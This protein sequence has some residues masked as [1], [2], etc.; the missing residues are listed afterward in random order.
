M[1][2]II[3]RGEYHLKFFSP[4]H[5]RPIFVL[6]IIS[7]ILLLIPY[8]FKGI[9]KGKYT[10]FIGI[11][12]LAVKLGDSLYRIHFENDVWYN[13]MPFNLCNVSLIFAGIYFIT[14]KRLYFNF[15]YFWFSGAIIAVIIPGFSVYHSSLYIYSFIASH[16]FEIFAVFYAFIH[17]DERVTFNGLITSI[18]G[19]MGLIGLAFLWNGIYGTN[20]MFM[21]DYIIGA[22]SFIK[23]FWF[24][25]IALTGLFTLSMLLMFLPFVNNQKEDLEEVII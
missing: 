4:E 18:I 8:L 9:E 3:T 13:T 14:R 23:P 1:F 24:Y 6:I 7:I 2:N 20:F 5:L 25:Q 22:V 12:C 11:L 16:M 15:V 10:T 21:A 19:Y 17:L